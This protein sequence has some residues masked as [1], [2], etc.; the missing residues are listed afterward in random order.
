MNWH[1]TDDS[2][3]IETNDADALV[4]ALD[5]LNIEAHI[6]GPRFVE[7]TKQCNTTVYPASPWTSSKPFL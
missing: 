4:I 6:I 5:R 1:E 3:I 7:I 2:V